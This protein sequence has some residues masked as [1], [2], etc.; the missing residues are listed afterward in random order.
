MTKHPIEVIT[1]VE[2][3]RCWSRHDKERLLA[4]CQE[5]LA[6]TQIGM[7]IGFTREWQPSF[8]RNAVEEITHA[9]KP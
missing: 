6:L 1:S 7:S 3:R 2:C 8:E 5:Q 4:A 9:G